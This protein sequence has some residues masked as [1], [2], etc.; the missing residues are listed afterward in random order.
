MTRTPVNPEL[1]TWARERAGRDRLALAGRFPKQS[2]WEAGELRPTLRQLENF[3][4]AV[5]VA[6]DHFFLPAPPQEPRPIPDFRTLAD[7][8]LSRPSPNLLDTIC[9]YQQRQQLPNWT[10]ALRKLIGKAKNAGMLALLNK[11]DTA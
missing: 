3:G 2:E 6:V 8:D 10:D 7:R 9:L 1:L 5:C 4:R 11:A